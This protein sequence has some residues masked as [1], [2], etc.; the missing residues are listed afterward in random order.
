[1]EVGGAILKILHFQILLANDNKAGVG[2]PVHQVVVA[3]FQTDGAQIGQENGR[4]VRIGANQ[5]LRCPPTLVQPEHD[6][7]NG[8]DGPLGQLGHDIHGTGGGVGHVLPLGIVDNMHDFLMVGIHG[9]LGVKLKVCQCFF[10]FVAE[11]LFYGEGDGNVVSLV[12]AAVADK[13]IHSG[14]QDKGLSHCTANHVEE[15]EFVISPA[16]VFLF[17]IRFQGA[18]VQ[19]KADVGLVVGSVWHYAGH[20]AI[21]GWNIFQPN[22]IKTVS[23][24]SLGHIFPSVK[25][26]YG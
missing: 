15:G 14:P 9:I 8:V 13:P 12:Q 17:Q 19:I 26:K 18:I 20:D 23:H 10:C 25:D 22:C 21:H 16:L 24:F 6:A 5:A 2:A 4:M 7:G 1:M 3:A 11:P